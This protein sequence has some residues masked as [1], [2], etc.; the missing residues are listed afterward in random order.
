MQD[1]K[2]TDQFAGH[3]IARQKMQNMKF[4]DKQT[5]ST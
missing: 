2:L 4:Q 3:E 5:Y 1:I